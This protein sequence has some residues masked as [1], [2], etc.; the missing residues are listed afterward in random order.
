MIEKF[1]KL[2]KHI[3]NIQKHLLRNIT[4]KIG[5]YLLDDNFLTKQLFST[6]TK[7]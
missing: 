5:I 4:C 6:H 1:L 7:Q 2:V 3:G